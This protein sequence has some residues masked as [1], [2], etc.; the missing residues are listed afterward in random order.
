MQIRKAIHTDLPKLKTLFIKTLENVNVKDYSPTQIKK[1]IK[2]G[3]S[4]KRWEDISKQ[5]EFFICESN[6]DELLGFTSINDKGFIH[7]FFVSAKY[8]NEGVGSFL[9][10]YLYK[11]ANE[12]NLSTLEAEVSITAK[13]FFEKFSFKVIKPQ[14]VFIDD[15]AFRN[16]KMLKIL[17]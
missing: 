2:I 13:S 14:I 11:K 15:T 10:H 8:Q 16:F 4:N 7:S 12:K 5:H 9:M 17:K 1:W 6:T 3:Q